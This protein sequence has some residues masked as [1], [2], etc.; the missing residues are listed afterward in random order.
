MVSPQRWLWKKGFASLLVPEW[1]HEPRPGPE[2]PAAHPALLPGPD[3]VRPAPPY[4]AFLRVP[5]A[6]RSAADCP[7][8]GQGRLHAGACSCIESYVMSRM[9]AE[10]PKVFAFDA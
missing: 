6:P 1:P 2:R 5:P 8:D 7:G 9:L 10:G 4:R 3:E